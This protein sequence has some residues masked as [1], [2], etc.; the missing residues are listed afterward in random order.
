MEQKQEATGGGKYWKKETEKDLNKKKKK[1]VKKLNSQEHKLRYIEGHARLI[2]RGPTL[3]FF[4]IR[5]EKEWN[6]EKET[7]KEEGRGQKF[8]LRILSVAQEKN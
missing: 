3:D 2:C 6:R 7:D 4:R 8:N 1:N 5:M